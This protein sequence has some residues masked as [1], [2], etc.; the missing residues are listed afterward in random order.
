MTDSEDGFNTAAVTVRCHICRSQGAEG[1]ELDWGGFEDWFRIGGSGTITDPNAAIGTDKYVPILD[2]K[3]EEC[4]RI[5]CSVVLVEQA[6][7]GVTVD[8]FI[9]R[10][11]FEWVNP[12]CFCQGIDDDFRGRPVILWAVLGIN[13]WRATTIDCKLPLLHTV[14]WYQGIIRL[15]CEVITIPHMALMR[16]DV[17]WNHPL[18]VFFR[19]MCALDLTCVTHLSSRW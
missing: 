6:V 18:G 12:G 10:R 5:V 9:Q 17:S 14:S 4:I 2:S 19:E 15:L 3:T 7:D 13:D 16:V 1:V 11:K 8:V